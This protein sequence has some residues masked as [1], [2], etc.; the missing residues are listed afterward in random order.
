MDITI[1]NLREIVKE[2]E[3]EG[4]V[5]SSDKAGKF[6]EKAVIAIEKAII[7]LEKEEEK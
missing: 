5:C 3:W 4:S 1:Q 2:V 7:I 6:L